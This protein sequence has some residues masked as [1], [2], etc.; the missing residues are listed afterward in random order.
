[1]I[2][3]DTVVVRNRDIIANVVDEEVVCL[4]IEKGNYYGM[5][6]IGSRIWDLLEHSISVGSMCEQL[7]KE[8]DVSHEDC[9]AHTMDF[10][11][12]LHAAGLIDV[13]DDK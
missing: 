10:V 8:Y 3:T 13:V 2:T 12:A 1:M 7:E 11:V 9:Q 6:S 5:D 4:N